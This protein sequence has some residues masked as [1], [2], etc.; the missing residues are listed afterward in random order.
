[1]VAGGVDG[2]R[3][4]LSCNSMFSVFRRA[5]SFESLFVSVGNLEPIAKSPFNGS[6]KKL[7][8]L[9]GVAVN[10]SLSELGV[11]SFELQVHLLF[12]LGFEV[13]GDVW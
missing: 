12:D 1:M 4:E 7:P 2:C 8:Q 11:K 3:V 10:G 5:M 13:F 9:V 6:R